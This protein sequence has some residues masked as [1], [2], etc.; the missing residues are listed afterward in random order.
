MWRLV[1]Q[2]L[3][4]AGQQARLSILIFHRVHA[5][6]DPLFPAEPDALQFERKMRAVAAGFNVL[7][8]PAAVAQLHAS[9]L[10]ARAL[11]ITFDDG[12]VDNLTV[13]AP[14]LQRLGL[15]ATFFIS[16]GFWNGDA[17]WNDRVVEAVR[18]TT[19]EVID[20]RERGLGRHELMTLVA[21]R[22][23]LARLIDEIKYLETPARDRAVRFVEHAAGVAPARDLM[24]G[25]EGL[26]ALH[27]AGMTLGAHTVSHPILAREPWPAARHEIVQSRRDLESLLQTRVGL[28]A[29]PNGKCGKDYTPAHARLLAQEGF[30]AALTTE[31]GVATRDCDLMQLPRFTPWRPGVGGFMAG[32][33]RNL[34]RARGKGLNGRRG[35]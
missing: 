3:S 4:P 5:R 7:P 24:L 11:A 32:L 8:L 6:P 27:R 26:R 20:L 28:F 17:M 29:Y 35:A 16:T 18:H 19:R 21:R 1:N 34:V 14:I 13:A 15:P 31:P 33:T 22:A 23:A 12:Y 9:T 2:V 30:D 25:R 10:P